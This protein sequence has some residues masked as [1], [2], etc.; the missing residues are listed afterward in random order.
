MR[1]ILMGEI[2]KQ[3]DRNKERRIRLTRIRLLAVYRFFEL[4]IY[5]FTYKLTFI[6]SIKKELQYK[7]I[8]Y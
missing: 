7:N 4:F 6:T 1:D 5:I 3:P 2:I 8:L